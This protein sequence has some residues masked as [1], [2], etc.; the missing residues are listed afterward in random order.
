VVE[1]LVTQP[2]FIENVLEVDHA[3]AV[4]VLVL[5]LHND[6]IPELHRVHEETHLILD[7]IVEII[8]FLLL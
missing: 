4:E 8:A 6:V 5:V 2:V 3:Q 1:A 7:S